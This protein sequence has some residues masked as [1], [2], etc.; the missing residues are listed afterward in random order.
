MHLNSS[1]F[2]TTG[3]FQRYRNNASHNL[4]PHGFAVLHSSQN[5]FQEEEKLCVTQLLEAFHSI[6]KS[7]DKGTE[8]DIVCLDFAK[9]S[10]SVCHARLL[11][12]LCQS[13]FGITISLIDR[14]KVYLSGRR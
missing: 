1:S 6:G 3:C 10:D 9:A 11:A 8:T 2:V 5:G 7:L 4:V 12:K 13:G 14:L